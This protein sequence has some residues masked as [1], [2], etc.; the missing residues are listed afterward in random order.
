MRKVISAVVFSM[1]A[2]GQTQIELKT[3]ARSVDF[4]SAVYTKPLKSGTALPATCTV[5]EAFLWFNAAPSSSI[6]LCLSAN[7]WTSQ[8]GLTVSNDGTIVGSRGLLNLVP[9]FGVSTISIDTGTQVN[10]QQVADSAVLL[11]ASNHQSGQALL[12]ASAGGTATA[13]SCQMTP[14]L[15]AYQI[16]MIVNWV[17]DVDAGSGVTLDI[18]TLGAKPVR[19]ADG[20]GEPLPGEIASGQMLPLWFDGSVFR[21]LTTDM[22]AISANLPP[23]C[24]AG[25]RGRMWHYTAP[26]G[27]KDQVSVCAKDAADAYAWQI[28]Y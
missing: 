9:G 23:L 16:G 17:P 15:G 7:T 13:Y 25:Q 8:G 19:L 1:V 12:C 10:V 11:T 20:T 6:A 2:H 14:T 21:I 28:L 26:P 4:Q 27:A 22:H 18:D 24:G 5:G 3:Q